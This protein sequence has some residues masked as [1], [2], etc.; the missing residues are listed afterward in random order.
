[1]IVM[2]KNFGVQ[3]QDGEGEQGIPKYGNASQE[4]AASQQES[5]V[6]SKP[7]GVAPDK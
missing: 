4:I 6:L 2:S 5:L 1:M 7:D 3:I